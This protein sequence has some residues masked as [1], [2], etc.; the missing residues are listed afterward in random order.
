MDSK[1]SAVED[2]GIDH[3]SRDIGMPEKFLDR[4]DVIA[5]FEEICSKRVP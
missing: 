2:V 4:A 3:G 1:T 5:P